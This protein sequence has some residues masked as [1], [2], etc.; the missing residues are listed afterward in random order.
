MSDEQRIPVS[1]LN[2]INAKVSLHLD[3]IRKC[4]RSFSHCIGHC[5]CETVVVDKY[6]LRKTLCLATKEIIDN[7]GV[8]WRFYHADRYSAGLL[9]SKQEILVWNF[10]LNQFLLSTQ[11]KYLCS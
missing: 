6:T 10:Y 8:S 1:V 3:E 2:E 7:Y 9:P 5:K 11:I 4:K